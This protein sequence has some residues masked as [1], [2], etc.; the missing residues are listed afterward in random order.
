LR[1]RAKGL[2][3]WPAGGHAVC[4]ALRRC[5]APPRLGCLGSHGAPGDRARSR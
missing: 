5:R 2:G 1:D 3:P 4:L